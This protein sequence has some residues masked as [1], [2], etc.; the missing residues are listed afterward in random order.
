MPCSSRDFAADV[1]M[2]ETV[3]AQPYVHNE[4]LR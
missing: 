1:D 2:D 3:M 4:R